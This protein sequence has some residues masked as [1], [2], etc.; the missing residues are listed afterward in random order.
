[1]AAQVQDSTF[2]TALHEGCV[3][4]RAYTWCAA[5][6][7]LT[8]YSRGSPHSGPAPVSPQRAVPTGLSGTDMDKKLL[9][10]HF[11]H[12]LLLTEHGEG[13]LPSYPAS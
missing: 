10:L 12:C 6:P 3:R 4:S 9:Q 11:H 8:S 5:C 13:E 1:M 2:K 7:V